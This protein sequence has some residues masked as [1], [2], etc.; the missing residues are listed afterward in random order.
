MPAPEGA[1]AAKRTRPLACPGAAPE[2]KPPPLS[3]KQARP[4]AAAGLSG[5]ALGFGMHSIR[6]PAMYLVVFAAAA[7]GALVVWCLWR[8]AP[9]VVVCGGIGSRPRQL[10]SLVA[11]I[12]RR[13][14]LARIPVLVPD[15]TLGGQAWAWPAVW[16]AALIV[17]A[18]MPALGAHMH[19]PSRRV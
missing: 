16:R 11:A 9:A 8:A 18:L 12:R 10:D 7:A 14:P 2:G 13:R 1:R 6:A 15:A 5:T 4:P 19:T 3:A 17:L